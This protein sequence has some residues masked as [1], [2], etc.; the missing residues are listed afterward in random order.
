MCGQGLAKPTARLARGHD[1]QQGGRLGLDLSR[2]EEHRQC[3][4][5]QDPAPHA[6]QA[7]EGE[8]EFYHEF[9]VGSQV[10]ATLSHDLERLRGIVQTAQEREDAAKRKEVIEY[11]KTLK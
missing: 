7:A 6:E 5:E 9:N 8:A 4:D 3:G 11:M 10:I 2:A 1:H